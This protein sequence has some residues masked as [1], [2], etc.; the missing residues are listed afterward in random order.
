IASPWSRGGYVNSEI[1]DLTS[2]NQFLEIF[3]T[4]KKGKPI[5]DPNIS[6]WRRTICGD[7]TSV[8]R[9][10]VSEERIKM[11]FLQKDPFMESVYSAKFKKLPDD[12]KVL[13]PEEIRLFRKNP[14]DSP[15]MPQQE[16][17]IRPS[18]GLFYQ[19]Y[20]DGKLNKTSK[21]FD[22]L[23]ASGSQVFG[24]KTLGSP[25]N[26]YAPG[27]YLQNVN[28]SNIFRNLRTWA[29]A[30]RPNGYVE[31]SWPL[32]SFEN[33][34]YHLRVYGPNGFFREYKGSAQ[35]PSIEI[36][37][38][39][40]VSE[41]DQMKLTGNVNLEMHNSGTEKL[42]ILIS[43]KSYKTG[44]VKK[45]LNPSTEHTE[46]TN[47]PIDLSKQFGWYDFTVTVEGSKTFERRY[48]GRVDTG[49]SGFSDPF[50]GRT[51]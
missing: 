19:L 8:F 47:I 10:T 23:F 5:K 4:V 1:F 18:N 31:Y 41:K 27:K 50:M 33:D 26:V 35:D 49:E 17:G 42:T 36:T 44:S 9:N 28:G 37:C 13:N 20:A 34:K 6:E 12:F 38:H 25:F 7:L 46:K 24:D 43:D 11:E 39:Y 32:Q 30:V 48:A 16:K 2:T 22:I 29:F 15:Y 45:M 51:I 40:E 21:S 14:Y 3:L